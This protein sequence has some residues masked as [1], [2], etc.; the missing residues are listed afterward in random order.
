MKT[1]II[2]RD[3]Y[4]NG[5]TLAQA[6]QE[7]GL[8]LSPHG[9]VCEF[10]RLVNK[11]AV[12]RLGDRD[13][14]LGPEMNLLEQFE[15]SARINGRDQEIDRIRSWTE[16]QLLDAVEAIH[17]RR[18][19]Q[20]FDKDRYPEM[21][22]LAQY[23]DREA[24]GIA[25]VF[26]ADYRR[27]LLCQDQYRR[28][29]NLQVSG[30]AAPAPAEAGRCTSVIFKES[31]VG[32][33][34]GR[35]MDSAIA[36]LAGLQGYGEPVLFE[37]SE[38]MGHSFMGTALSLNEHG[39]V[40]QGS[41]IGYP[42]EATEAE[43][44]V[45]LQ[46]MVIRN[47]KTVEEAIDLI[48]RYSGMSGPTNLVMVDA[49]GDGAAVEKSKNT[50]AVRRTTTPWI[51]TTDGIAMEPK[52][53]DIQGN[54][55]ALHQFHESRYRLIERLLQ[56]A[57]SDPSVEEMKR[58]MRDHSGPSPVCKHIEEMPP[59]YPL[60]T[61]YSF[62]LAPREGEYYFWTTRPGPEYPCAFEPTRHTFSFN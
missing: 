8:M 52:T 5:A 59:N 10:Y 55:T 41:S 46:G 35:N 34:I 20:T 45:D 19:E 6:W 43:F 12:E 40:I 14:M 11:E 42:T 58:I 2:Q 51:F 49:E 16:P 9:E 27:V 28:L 39:L 53:A 56:E 44:W 31:P 21:Q 25:D 36:S 37:L 18:L 62:V 26:G 48:G 54:G 24:R 15:Y 47:C 61:L 17:R 50:Y 60:A 33:I 4:E 22:G 29:V 13:A 57:E 30:Q 7:D 32:P 38:E 3:G 1:R 23:Q